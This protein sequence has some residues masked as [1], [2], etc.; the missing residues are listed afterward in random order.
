MENPKT[1]YPSIDE[2]E[3][4]YRGKTGYF[5]IK[6]FNSTSDI[7]RLRLDSISAKAVTIHMTF[8]VE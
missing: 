2:R 5:C 8:A 1:E 6:W 7:K 3:I 4:G